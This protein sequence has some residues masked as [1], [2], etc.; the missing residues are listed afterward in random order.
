MADIQQEFAKMRAFSKVAAS[1]LSKVLENC[2]KRTVKESD[3]LARV[4][5]FSFDKD[6]KEKIMHAQKI[7]LS[8]VTSQIA[9]VAEV[10]ENKE[11]E[12]KD[13]EEIVSVIKGE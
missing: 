10:I 3:S 1:T 12:K 13:L 11:A 7:K 8:D 5:Y 2:E 6:G 9:K 4:E